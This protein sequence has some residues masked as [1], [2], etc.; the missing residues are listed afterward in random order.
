M[1]TKLEDKNFSRI[2]IKNF[3]Y[4]FSSV[5]ILKLGGVLLTI[6]L[7]RLLLP[8]LFGIYGLVLSIITLAISFTDLGI[9]ETA[10]TYISKSIGN[11]KK[12][13]ARSYFRFFLRI[14]GLFTIIVILIILLFSHYLSFSIFKK[15]EIFL[16]L[17][18]ASIYVLVESFRGYITIWF[19]ATKNLKPIAPLEFIIQIAK[20][21]LSVIAISILSDN[22]K[23]SGVFL[24]FS[25]A[26]IIYFIISL[27][28]VLRKDKL[29]LIGKII[30]VDTK[31]AI[32]FLTFMGFVIIFLTL[33]GSVDTLMLGVFVSSEFI[34]YYRAALGL[35]TSVAALFSFSQIL[36]PMFTQIRRERLER[37]ISKTYRYI[38]IISVPAIF[39]II[40][41]SKY[42]IYA[43]YGSSY[44]L[45]FNSLIILSPLL[46]IA[47]LISLYST[48]FKARERPK[49]LSKMMFY[50]LII[51][52]VLNYVLIT[53]LLRFGERYAIL[54]AGLATVLSQMF[55]LFLLSNKTS[56]SLKVKIGEMGFGRAFLSSIV[57]SIFLFIFI[58]YIDMNLL[59]GIIGVLLSIGIYILFMFLFKGINKED[60]KLLNYLKPNA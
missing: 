60:F 32:K 2:A 4:Q 23:I 12:D 19:A 30:Q 7:A 16:P 14:K 56:K 58:R 3:G 45:S 39:G 8:E 21:V 11:N 44:L 37:G 49:E 22:L 5:F 18:I 52:I 36:L 54:G 53:Y 41:I 9:T 33:L 6:I 25:I 46:I 34:G 26:G 15:P 51:N 31:K 48:I 29:F 42:L 38:V 1:A 59:S 35:I 47:P 50:S 10:L 24:A 28:I 20:I 40:L 17:I 57:M 27:L 43:L 13:K 55:L